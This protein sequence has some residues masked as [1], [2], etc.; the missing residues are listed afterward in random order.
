MKGPWDDPLLLREKLAQFSTRE[1]GDLWGCSHVHILRAARRHGIVLSRITSQ[2]TRQLGP[3]PP[4]KML[5]I[6]IE[7]APNIAD[8]WDLF[9]DYVSIN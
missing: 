8:I 7:R 6:D 1:L 3:I 9:H 4:A 5:L 2:Y